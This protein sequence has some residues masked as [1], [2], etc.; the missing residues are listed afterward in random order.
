MRNVAG[1][2]FT[3]SRLLAD[4]F[5][6]VCLPLIDSGLVGSTDL[7]GVPREQK[8]LKGHLPKVIYHRMYFRIRRTSEILAADNEMQGT[9]SSKTSR[10]TDMSSFKTSAPLVIH[11]Y[12]SQQRVHFCF[13][14]FHSRLLSR[15]AALFVCNQRP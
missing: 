13:G 5:A 15:R 6:E 9:R 2:P 3:F 1:R 14:T 10:R 11:Y 12:L 4:F 8:M 7:G